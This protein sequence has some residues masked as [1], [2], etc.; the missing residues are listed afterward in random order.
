M[1]ETFRERLC[2]ELDQA[3]FTFRGV[4]KDGGQ[5]DI[6][7][8]GSAMNTGSK[9]VLIDLAMDIT[10]RTRSEREVQLLQ[11]KLR[12]QT[13]HDPLT[14][15]FNRRYLDATIG[16]ELALALRT[17]SALLRRSARVSH[18]CCRCGGEEF[19]V[20]LPGLDRATALQRAEELRSMT[21]C[22]PVPYADSLIEVTASFG[23]A[24]YPL[25][26]LTGGAFTGDD[27]IGAA[28]SAMYAAKKAGRNRAASARAALPA[29]QRPE[30]LVD[31]R[32]DLRG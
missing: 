2:G 15:L 8:H 18:I 25:D 32:A 31:S 14:G 3:V 16:R 23:V 4:R 12:E 6:E 13:N 5:V 21:A 26:A 19:L 11:V 1:A 24:S 10:E 30:W 29:S 17:F 27:L 20:V 22:T 7:C 28:D 9:L